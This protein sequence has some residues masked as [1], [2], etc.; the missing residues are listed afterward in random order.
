[1]YK[2]RSVAD[3]C[4]LPDALKLSKLYVHFSEQLTV[5][6]MYLLVDVHVG[7]FS[8]NPNNDIWL[9]PMSK[10]PFLSVLLKRC[11]LASSAEYA[12]IISQ[13]ESSCLL[14]F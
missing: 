4:R 14:K 12:E 11:S 13:M 1:M 9:K 10:T 8:I 5:C 6:P 3:K 2:W 7:V